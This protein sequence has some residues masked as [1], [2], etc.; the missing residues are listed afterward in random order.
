MN[1]PECF[2]DTYKGVSPQVYVIPESTLLYSGSRQSPKGQ[3]IKNGK[4]RYTYLS[5]FCDAAIRFATD[6]NNKP[7]FLT[8]YKVIKPITVFVQE[9]P[10]DT[11]YFDTVNSYASNEAQCLCKKEFHGYASL[12]KDRLDDIGLC[13]HIFE[14]HFLETIEMFAVTP[15]KRSCKNLSGGT[16]KRKS[17]RSRSRSRSR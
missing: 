16:R 13:N 5:E 1:L 8:K 9:P 11:Y 12:V 14:G 10:Y 6:F 3:N 7:G 15:E 4:A 17:S 2:R